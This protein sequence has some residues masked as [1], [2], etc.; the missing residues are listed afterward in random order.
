MEELKFGTYAGEDIDWLVL[1]NSE[2]GLLLLTKYCI[3]TKAFDENPNPSSWENCSLRKWLNNE[4]YQS[5][6]SDMEKERICNVLNSNKA[7]PRFGTEDFDDTTDKVFLLSVFEAEKYFPDNSSRMA[8]PTDFAKK[9]GIY[10]S[11]NHPWWWLRTTGNHANIACE[12]YYDGYIDYLGHSM[13]F[14]CNGVR[15]AIRIKHDN[16]DKI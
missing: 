8:L 5:A 2:E 4:F 7:N 6:F 3:D 11:W 13:N 1:D 12:V 9:N 15:P 14:A 10:M 16:P